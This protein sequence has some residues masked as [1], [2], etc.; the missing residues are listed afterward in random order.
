MTEV[1]GIAADQLRS[2]VERIERLTEEKA[3]LQSDIKDIFAEAK[4][5]GFDVKVIR[6]LIAERKLDEADRE[7]RDSLLELYRRALGALDGT[8][9]GDAAL[10]RVA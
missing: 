5:N 9:L 8:P 3:A 1:A 6:L 7:E 4:S 10:A 2:F